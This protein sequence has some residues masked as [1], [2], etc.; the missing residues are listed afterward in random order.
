M[1]LSGLLRFGLDSPRTPCGRDIRFCEVFALEQKWRAERLGKG[2][3]ETIA[4]VETGGMTPL[5]RM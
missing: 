1:V 3:S 2:V 5:S 4:Q